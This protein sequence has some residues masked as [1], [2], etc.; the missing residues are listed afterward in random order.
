MKIAAACTTFLAFLVWSCASYS[1]PP[2]TRAQAARALDKQA[3]A[4]LGVD[5]QSLAFLFSAQPSTLLLKDELVRAGSW[6]SLKAL[7]RA[8][9]VKIRVSRSVE[10]DFLQI[11]L[12][13]QGR[14]IHEAL[15]GR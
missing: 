5:L 11:A 1:A 14:V 3:I 6:N 4:S 7:E 8:G 13:P 10:G 15:S 12:T 2:V 9:Y